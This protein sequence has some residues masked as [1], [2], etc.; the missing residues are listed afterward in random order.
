M[1]ITIAPLHVVALELDIN[2]VVLEINYP[3]VIGHVKIYGLEEEVD[4]DVLRIENV[5]GQDASQDSSQDASQDVD[6][7]RGQDVSQEDVDLERGQDASLVR[8]QEDVD[9]NFSDLGIF[10]NIIQIIFYIIYSF[11]V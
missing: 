9:N 8:G 5:S 4:K 6:L 3:L 11:I 2:A 7:V 10:E 1:D